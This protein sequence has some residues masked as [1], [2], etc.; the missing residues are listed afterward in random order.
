MRRFV[1]IN[2]GPGPPRRNAPFVPGVGAKPEGAASIA[3]PDQE[4]FERANLPAAA[5]ST[6]C[7]SATPRAI[8]RWCRTPS[9][10]RAAAARRGLL[11]R[12]AALAEDPGLRKYLELRANAL[13]SDEY[14]RAIAHGST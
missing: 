3:R 12:A 6:P 13:R 10:A 8:S 9:T 4:E 5:A 7:S 2:Y 1:E 14:A 11:E